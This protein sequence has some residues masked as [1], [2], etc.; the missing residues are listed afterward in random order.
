MSEFSVG[1]FPRAN[2]QLK[3]SMLQIRDQ[4][5]NFPWHDINPLWL[6]QTN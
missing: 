1:T 4:F 3:A 5:A 2:H 6:R